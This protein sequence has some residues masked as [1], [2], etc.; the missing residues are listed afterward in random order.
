VRGTLVVSAT[1]NSKENKTWKTQHKTTTTIKIITKAIINRI[2]AV[3]SDKREKKMPIILF[4]STGF[5]TGLCV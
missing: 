5:S 2:R 1:C 3:V 4:L